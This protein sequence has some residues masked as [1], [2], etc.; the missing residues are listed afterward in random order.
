[1]EKKN[2]Q[3]E[4]AKANAYIDS[5][6][7]TIAK[8]PFRQRF[9]FAP[10]AGWINDPAGMVQI[11]GWY[12]LFCEHYPFSGRPEKMFWAHARSRDMVHWERLPEALVPSEPY[13]L[14]ECLGGI[15]TGSGID[16]DGTLKVL[17]TA[18]SD[19]FGETQALAISKDGIHFEKYKH[20]PVLRNVP[21]GLVQKDCRDPKVWR[22][23]KYFYMTLGATDGK[24]GK[25]LLYRSTTLTEWE[26]LGVIWESV[27]EYGPM[28]ECPNFFEV[29]GKWVLIFAPLKLENRKAMYLVGDF[30]YKTYKFKP[31]TVGEIDWG[32]DYYAPQILR[33]DSGRT[34]ILGWMECWPAHPWYCGNDYARPDMLGYEY[35]TQ[36]R[37]FTGSISIPRTIS[38]CPDGKLKFDPLPALLTLRESPWIR[39]N[40]DVTARESFPMGDGIHGEIFAEFDLT[41][42]DAEV[43]GFAL[44]SSKA[45][46]TL[47]KFDLKHGELI[48][49]RTR[50][51]NKAAVVRKCVL[52]SAVKDKLTVRM[53][54]DSTSVEIFTDGNRTVMSSCIYTPEESRG[55]CIFAEGGSAHVESLRTWGMQDA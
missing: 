36:E 30:D 51:G 9:H 48:F 23:G 47:V 25:V 11:D 32:F 50:S 49:D 37:G 39:Y 35:D 40:F 12:H 10:Y 6:K 19:A 31:Q 55:L 29:D 21:D 52:E 45:H 34:I 15:Y 44:R 41:Q 26:Y 24:F 27:G 28:P 4:L 16:D 20:N 13:E 1:M 17:Y 54:L 2:F 46:E 42:T 8:D 53:F 5:V 33:D 7:D 3:E 14:A 18:H 22:R 38:V 43:I